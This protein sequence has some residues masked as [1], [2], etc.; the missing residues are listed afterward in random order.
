MSRRIRVLIADDQTLFRQGLRRLLEAEPDIEVVG[1]AGNGVDVEARVRETRPDVVLMDISMP[2][3]D[4]V[5][6]T[7]RILAENRQVG[8]IILTVERHDRSVFEAIRAGAQGYLLKDS[9][10]DEVT[11]AVRAVYEGKSL[12]DPALATRVLL[13]FRRISSGHGVDNRLGGLSAKE[14][15]ILRLLA[16]GM[17]NKEIGNRLFISEKTVK[18]RLTAIFH[19]LELRDRVQAAVYALQLGLV[20]AQ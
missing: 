15:E 1:E 13:E 5:T 17:T 7:R 6:A 14:V 8:I 3:V 16:A 4:G 2:I 20:P 11:K 12:I 10:V 18:N 19:K 9:Q